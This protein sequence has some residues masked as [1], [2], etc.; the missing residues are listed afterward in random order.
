[1]K[2]PGK[3]LEDITSRF[4]RWAYV[5]CRLHLQI[6]IREA[7]WGYE[8]SIIPSTHAAG[9]SACRDSMHSHCDDERSD[10]VC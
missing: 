9:R 7:A 8:G 4:A 6:G 5:T 10:K 3:H 2:T 1:M